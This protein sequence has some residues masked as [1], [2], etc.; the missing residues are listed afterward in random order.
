MTTY[1][2]PLIQNEIIST[3]NDIILKKLVR[4]VNE[5]KYFSVLADETSDIS[6]TEQCSICVRYVDSENEVCEDFLQFTP[7]T[8]LTGKGIANTLIESLKKFGLNC[9]NMV[10]QGYDG[11]AVMSGKFN[12][13]QKFLNEKYNLAIYVHCASHSLNLAISDAC[14]L[15]AIRNCMGVIS[16]I[17]TFFN[18]PKRL[19]VL[20]SV[21]EC[22]LPEAA[23]TRLK[24]LCATR[25][26]E[27]HESVIV[28]I[29]LQKATHCALQKISEWPDKNSSSTALQLLGAMEKTEFQVSLQVVAKVF[30]VTLPLCRMLQMK[31]LDLGA[32]IKLA[33]DV[34]NIIRKFRENATEEFSSLFQNVK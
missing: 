11:A 25:W 7:I 19:A 23:A 17:H 24:R 27:R 8:D 14:D 13:A 28:F 1:I 10:G 18:T 5:A 21:I 22:T 12:G 34:N 20:Q 3:C 29:E 9:E 26:V 33:T 31:N 16:N 30:A 6:A 15:P 4:K 32:A 2:S